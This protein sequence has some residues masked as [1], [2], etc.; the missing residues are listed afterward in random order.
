[1]APIPVHIKHAGKTFDVQLDV[2]APPSTFKQSI[3][4]VTGVP[5]DRMKV[6]I[7]GG[8]LKDDT[9]WKK[10]APKEGQ[11]FMV[12][13][14]AGELPKPPEKPVV[15]LEDLDDSELASSVRISILSMSI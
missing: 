12:I 4:E 1:M 2:D 6:M 7:K 8:V 14:A 3:Y 11:T 10:V 13:G 9:P 15:F 5:V